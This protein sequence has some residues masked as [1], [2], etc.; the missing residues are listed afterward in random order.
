MA[1]TANKVN[2]SQIQM[3]FVFEMAGNDV[4]KG[5]KC[6]LQAFSAFPSQSLP[7]GDLLILNVFSKRSKCK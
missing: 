6:C 5:E 3:E 7:K 2:I 4:G 1:F